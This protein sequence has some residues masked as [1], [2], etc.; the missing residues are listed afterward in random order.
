A[1]RQRR[2][3]GREIGERRQLGRERPRR[4]Q[5]AAEIA[6][7]EREGDAA[8]VVAARRQRLVDGGQ[9]RLQR[10]QVAAQRL[11]LLAQLVDRRRL[12]GGDRHGLLTRGRRQLRLEGR[13]LLAQAGAIGRRRSRRLE[14]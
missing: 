8:G 2:I 11:V 6:D 10:R 7:G 9:L 5:R 3:L 1:R 14:R 4:R 12:D 13:D